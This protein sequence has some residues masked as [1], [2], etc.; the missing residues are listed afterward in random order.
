[1]QGLSVGI[2]VWKALSCLE[3]GSVHWRGEPVCEFVGHCTL[4]GVYSVE[5]WTLG[6]NFF[7]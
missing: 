1:M 3:K 7:N 5:E 2:L 6:C 4:G